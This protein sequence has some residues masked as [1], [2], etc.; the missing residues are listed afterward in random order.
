MAL[1]FCL[2][3]AISWRPPCFIVATTATAEATAMT[4]AMATTPT[5]V[6]VFATVNSRDH[7]TAF[8]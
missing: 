2:L 8:N 7:Y 1:H 4:M 5:I 3:F 6:T